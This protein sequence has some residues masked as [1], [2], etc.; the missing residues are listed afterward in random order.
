MKELFIETRLKTNQEFSIDFALAIAYLV[1]TLYLPR[2]S[3]I[4]SLITV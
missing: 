4:Y 3:D 2:P 1:P